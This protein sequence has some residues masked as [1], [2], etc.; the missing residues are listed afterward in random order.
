M[1][2][3][4]GVVSIEY[5]DEGSAT[6]LLGGDTGLG[7][8]TILREPDELDGQSVIPRLG[9]CRRGV[10]RAV[11]DHKKLKITLRLAKDFDGRSR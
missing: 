11:I 10:A 7:S 9:D 4:P 8:A 3:K 2:G 5:C 1:I 6:M